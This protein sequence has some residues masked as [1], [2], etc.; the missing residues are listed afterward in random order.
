L[1]LAAVIPGIV[2]CK[3][4][5]EADVAVVVAASPSQDLETH[6]FM[7][8]E[9]GP[10]LD[11]DP[12]DLDVH[13]TPDGRYFVARGKW[14]LIHDPAGGAAQPRLI[15]LPKQARFSDFRADDVLL[16][17]NDD[18]AVLSTATGEIRKLVEAP[19]DVGDFMIIGDELVAFAAENQI[20]H[21]PI[22]G[23]DWKRGGSL[24]GTQGLS[25]PVV[26]GDAAIWAGARDDVSYVLIA[27][28]PFDDIEIAVE[29]DD[30][31]EI[32]GHA[33]WA[34]ESILYTIFVGARGSKAKL[35]RKTGDKT[36]LLFDGIDADGTNF[37]TSAEQAAYCDIEGKRW[38]IDATSHYELR[39]E[40]GDERVALVASGHIVARRDG[41]IVELRSEHQPPAG[42]TPPLVTVATI[43][44]P[45]P[46]PTE[47]DATITP[48]VPAD[49][50]AAAEPTNK[51]STSPGT[52]ELDNPEPKVTGGSLS[53]D[54]VRRIARAH[55]N[56]ILS[57]HK[58]HTSAPG[59]LVIG[60]QYVIAESG[61]VTSSKISTSSGVPDLDACVTKAVRRWQFPKPSGGEANVETTY[62]FK[63]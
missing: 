56:E 1:I 35:L 18:F 3:R 15:T 14:L 24:A 51:P 49:D 2:A 34:G 57:C 16:R 59:K 62:T 30:A 52:L 5:A 61:K 42:A 58:N 12:V 13:I 33:A 50:A 38:R 43:T 55:K 22:V 29:L 26:R 60:L 41:N 44:P 10:G 8:F 9:T 53:P 37:C 31:N 21:V 32:I 28:T 11:L 39:L 7:R 63:L 36:D 46:P 17:E 54:I 40:P 27:R 45:A 4:N 20:L 19:D 25:F 48:P 6:P 23:G 47:P